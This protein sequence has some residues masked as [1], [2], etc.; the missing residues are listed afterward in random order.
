MQQMALSGYCFAIHIIPSMSS[1]YVKVLNNGR[2]SL[3]VQGLIFFLLF[4]RFT[5]TNW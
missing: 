2:L 4:D 1:V 3:Y 5:K